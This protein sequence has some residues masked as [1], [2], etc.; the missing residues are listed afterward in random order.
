METRL[1]G[2]S[3]RRACP[4]CDFV[5]WGNYSIG[6]GALLFKE[7][8]VLLVRRAQ[9]PGKGYWTNP[10]GFIEQFET[11]EETVEREVW[12]ETG[13]KAKIRSIVALRDQ[14]RDPHNLYVAFS[15]D[16]VEGEPKADG[17]E[18]DGAGF[19]SYEETLQMN[20]APFTRWLLEIAFHGKDPGLWPD[21][22]AAEPMPAKGLFK[23]STEQKE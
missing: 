16:Y 18:V 6:V 7:K 15:M 9:N 17:V 23:I 20:V 4:K 11:I 21:T 8:R 5:Y 1:I 14:P 12:E 2:D 3:D 19:F 13:I 22:H 10:G